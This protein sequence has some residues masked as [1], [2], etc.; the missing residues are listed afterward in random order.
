VPDAPR[1]DVL[2]ATRHPSGRPCPAVEVQH[3]CSV[4]WQVEPGR[5]GLRAPMGSK[6]FSRPLHEPDDRSLHF[7][8]RWNGRHVTVRTG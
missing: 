6:R 3:E 1:G 4:G 8:T 2:G 7:H 5:C